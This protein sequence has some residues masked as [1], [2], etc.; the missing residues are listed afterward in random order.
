MFLT[1]PMMYTTSPFTGTFPSLALINLP[2]NQSINSTDRLPRRR[3]KPV[4]MDQQRQLVASSAAP[5]H[6][7]RARRRGSP[8]APTAAVLCSRCSLCC[9]AA[10]RL[11]LRSQVSCGRCHKAKPPL[12][13]M[14]SVKVRFVCS[15]SASFPVPPPSRRRKSS[16]SLSLSRA[17]SLSYTSNARTHFPKMNDTTTPPRPSL[18]SMHLPVWAK[19][20]ETSTIN[21]PPNSPCTTTPSLTSQQTVLYLPSRPPPPVIPPIPRSPPSRT[22]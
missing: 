21:N 14:E 19:R 5:L 6:R 11:R 17:R 18:P 3:Q 15:R 16:R 1:A 2:I 8:P 13:R 12:L 7:L 22:V 4:G 20:G 10:H 9:G